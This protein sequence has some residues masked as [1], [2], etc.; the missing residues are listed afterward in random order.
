MK[1]NTARKASNYAPPKI[2]EISITGG[3][4]VMTS[5]FGQ[6]ENYDIFNGD[7]EDGTQSW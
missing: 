7:N 6:T 2:D 4:A 3:E 1:I 5:N